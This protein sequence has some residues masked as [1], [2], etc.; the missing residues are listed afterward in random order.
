MPK[1]ILSISYDQLLLETRAAILRKSGH[2]VI[3]VSDLGAFKQ[4]LEEA[5]I[6]LVVV[7]HTVSSQDRGQAYRLMGE[8]ECECPVIE[9]YAT[10]TPPDS[11]AH[12][13]LAV[14]DRTFQTDLVQ[15]VRQVLA[16]QPN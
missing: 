1:T 2:K 3:S 12:F 4:A 14:H 8:N 16:D 15:L 5:D 11:P 10:A 6:D 7:G 9:L 13:H